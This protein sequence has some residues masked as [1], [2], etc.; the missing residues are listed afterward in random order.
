MSDTVELLVIGAGPAGLAV[1][2]AAAKAGVPC[3]LLDGKTV[4]SAIERYPLGMT[5]FSTPEK[6]EIGGVPLVTSTEKPTRR[7][8]LIYYRR[9]AEAFRLDIRVGERATRIVPEVDGTFSVH[10]QRRH[11]ATTYRARHVVVATGYYEQPNLLGVP[12]ESL[13]HVAHY[14]TEGHRHWKQRV[15]IVGGGN[16]AVDAALESWRAGAL[17]TMILRG[18][19]LHPTVKPWVLPDITN[20]LKEGSIGWRQ[21]TQVTAIAPTHVQLRHA[22]GVES[23]LPA[24]VV[25][26][27]TGYRPDMTLLRAAGVPIDAESGVPAHDERTMQTPVPGLYI[28]GVI[29]GGDDDNRLFIENTRHHGDVI[30]ATIR[31]E[32]AAP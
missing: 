4:V 7:D 25:L 10:V 3:L 13:P 6:I 8:G 20:R 32:T 24:D 16:S 31:Q 27:M 21:R 9:V 22:D 2:V 26:L 29:A 18:D 28:A 30:L 15:V 12:G 14:F 11:D 23:T 1:G 5:F 17:V 19:A